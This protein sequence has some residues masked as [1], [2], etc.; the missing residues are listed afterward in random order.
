MDRRRKPGRTRCVVAGE[1][2]GVGAKVAV[3][4]DAI[5]SADSAFAR[6]HEESARAVWA[7]AAQPEK[8]WL[9]R[10]V[11]QMASGLDLDGG[12]PAGT[13]GAGATQGRGQE[14]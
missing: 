10:R 4:A 11:S 5:D 9:I 7:T 1:D 2:R 8:D 6:G 3:V 12:L 14:V 13:D